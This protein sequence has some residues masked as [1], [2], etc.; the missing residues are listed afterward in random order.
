MGLVSEIDLDQ[1]K[2]NIELLHGIKNH[3]MTGK[4]KSN[5]VFIENGHPATLA[6]FK[7]GD[8]VLVQWDASRN[9]K[10][11]EFVRKGAEVARFI[12]D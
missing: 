2:M 5:T 7:K 4:L 10:S 3:T 12:E 6:D 9:D 11:I 1:H 8:V